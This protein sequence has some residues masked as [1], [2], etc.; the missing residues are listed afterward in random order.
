MGA[1]EGMIRFPCAVLFAALA[2]TTALAQDAPQATPTPAP[3]PTFIPIPDDT[4]LIQPIPTPTLTVVPTPT[5]VP[6]SRAARTPRP[7]PRATPAPPPVVAPAPI[8][9]PTPLPA[10]AEPPAVQPPAAQPSARPAPA[11]PVQPA[12][13]DG[14]SD[15][16]P[17]LLGLAALAGL[18]GLALFLLRRRRDVEPDYAYQPVAEPEP[19]REVA[20]E[21]DPIAAPIAP[22]V[23][24]SRADLT[25]AFRPTRAGLNMLSATVEGELTVTNTGEAAASEVRVRA[26]LLTAHPGLDRDVAALRGEPVARPAA[27]P[28]ALGPG[29]AR[30]LR[31]VAASPREALQVL[32]AGERPMFV[33]VVAIDVGHADGRAGQAYA[34]GVERAGSSKLAPFWLD[35]PPK[36]Y[37]DVAAR[38]HGPAAGR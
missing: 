27:P 36:S 34:V 31:V 20:V 1:S 4:P 17:W 8:A 5:P 24:P 21:P 18:G 28:F 22:S 7:I 29:E 6:P 25:L 26:V 37:T 15:L 2:P 9:S 33:P 3:L 14:E 32:T 16:W 10:P 35:V 19:E 30:S 23:S 38:E 13:T 12:P 11:S